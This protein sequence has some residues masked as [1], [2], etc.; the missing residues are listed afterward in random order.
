MER[1]RCFS[2]NS[3]RGDGVSLSLELVL[4]CTY[5][6]TGHGDLIIVV[7]LGARLRKW[8]WLYQV[9]SSTT[10]DRR[11]WSERACYR[12]ACCLSSLW[13]VADPSEIVVGP[14]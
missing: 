8:R 12:V 6:S 10:L 13:D 9:H 1:E 5:A 14:R 3:Y 4:G 11:E 7:A 2:I